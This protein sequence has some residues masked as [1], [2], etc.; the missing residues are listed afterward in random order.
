MTY[1]E[2][3]PWF[4]AFASD[5][6]QDAL[7]DAFHKI[8]S[9]FLKISSADGT[10]AFL[11]LED[12]H[13][14][15]QIVDII[16]D[17]FIKLGEGFLK[18]ADTSLELDSIILK[19]FPP[20]PIAP[21]NP[22]T[23]AA[24][25][26]EGAPTPQPDFL[27]VDTELKIQSADLKLLGTDFL[28][29]DTAPNLDI[30]KTNILAV[31]DD[32]LKLSTDATDSGAA[33]HKLGTDL[34]TLGSGDNSNSAGL[35]DALKI[36]GG[37]FLKVGD[38][39]GDVAVDWNKLHQDFFKLGG[40]S[41]TTT[42]ADALASGPA[43]SGPLGSDFAALDKS[44][45]LLNQALGATGPGIFK[46]VD[47]ALDQSGVKGQAEDRTLDQVAHLLG[48]GGHGGHEHG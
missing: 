44:L 46:L 28:K 26:G 11:K 30:W 3:T 9:D 29:L 17:T 42:V 2:T 32:F 47:A 13:K 22:S 43:P 16:G 41:P 23:D 24:A 6:S 21:P 45:L 20:N 8:D 39:F 48:L 10:A 35:N 25:G 4:R 38:A 7:N 27:K 34:V 31:S 5:E 33:F 12:S 1:A 37:D 15:T 36:L 19:A 14:N 18:H 40:G